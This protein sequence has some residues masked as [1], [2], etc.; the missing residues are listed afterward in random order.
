MKIQAIGGFKPVGVEFHQSVPGETLRAAYNF[1]TS[2]GG[3]LKFHDNSF[4]RNSHPL[5]LE[6]YADQSFGLMN[7]YGSTAL[8]VKIGTGGAFSPIRSNSANFYTA[9]LGGYQWNYGGEEQN[10]QWQGGGEFGIFPHPQNDFDIT[11]G[12][13]VGFP[14]EA[15]TDL[16]WSTGLGVGWGF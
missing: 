7:P 2:A 5:L 11:L 6:G 10:T 9:L 12:A 3:E 16:S 1:Q 15:R 13:K 14:D 8:G 4:L